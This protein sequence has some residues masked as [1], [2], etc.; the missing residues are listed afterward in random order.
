MRKI[1]SQQEDALPQSVTSVIDKNLF[2]K[3][4]LSSV[5]YLISKKFHGIAKSEF[6]KL[7]FLQVDI[8]GKL[9]HRHDKVNSYFLHCKCLHLNG[10]KV[11]TKADM[12][13]YKREVEKI[14]MGCK[15]I[16]QQKKAGKLLSLAANQDRTQHLL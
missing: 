4:L 7:I 5:L 8:Q 11:A 15:I 10:C 16:K 13:D 3:N 2:P 9:V 1:T 6:V 12:K 14:R